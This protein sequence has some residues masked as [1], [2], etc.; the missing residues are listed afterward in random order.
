MRHHTDEAKEID[1]I[2]PDRLA[3]KLPKLDSSFE[4]PSATDR[5]QP[6]KHQHDRHDHKHYTDEAKE[7]D[8]IS[9]DRLA[10]ELPMLNSSLEVPFA[11][12]LSLSEA[13]YSNRSDLSLG[14]EDRLADTFDTIADFIEHEED[15]IHW[16]SHME[17]F[18]KNMQCTR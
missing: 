18:A 6:M 10:A 12:V 15:V 4:V 13:W 11:T 7:I 1:Y 8:Y 17:K 16:T 5:E 9:P 3:T 2:P 14:I